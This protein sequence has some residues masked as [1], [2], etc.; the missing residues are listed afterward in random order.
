MRRCYKQHGARGTGGT[1][2]A[3]SSKPSCQAGPN[4]ETKTRGSLKNA[5]SGIDLFKSPPFKSTAAW[6]P[7]ACQQSPLQPRPAPPTAVQQICRQV[8]SAGQT[9][10][11]RERHT[12]SSP[13]NN[14]QQ[15]KA[16][17][18]PTAAL[19]AARAPMH[20]RQVAQNQPS[21]AMHHC[22]NQP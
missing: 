9:E 20:P 18:G 14:N 3:A 8:A 6:P 5:P 17:G 15:M 1:V 11:K 16:R 13:Y 19:P 4:G 10:E 7:A 12:H 22:T 2:K 21:T